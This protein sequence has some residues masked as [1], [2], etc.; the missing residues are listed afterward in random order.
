LIW[1]KKEICAIFCPELNFFN[2]I[3]KEKV[4]SGAISPIASTSMAANMSPAGWAEVA[5]TEIEVQEVFD[6]FKNE[7]VFEKG[8]DAKDAVSVVQNMLQQ[9]SKPAESSENASAMYKEET[10]IGQGVDVKT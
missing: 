9:A 8:E 6:E 3:K 5:A 4:M 10:G 2:T 1:T 7:K